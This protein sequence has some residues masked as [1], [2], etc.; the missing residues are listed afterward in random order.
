MGPH[1]YCI[2]Y[3]MKPRLEFL[4]MNRM[5]L[6]LTIFAT[7]GS[8]LVSNSSFSQ[9]LPPANKA[10][11]AKIIDGPELELAIDTWAIVRWT[12]THPGGDDEHFGAVHYGIKPDDLSQTAKSHIRLNRTHPETTFRVRIPGLKPQTT[13]YYLVTSMASNGDSDRIKSAVNHFTTPASGQR[14]VAELHPK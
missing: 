12:S 14:I 11:N 6:K 1:A 4:L 2:I 13:Y 8:L 5:L 10:E 3:P 9:L 7:A